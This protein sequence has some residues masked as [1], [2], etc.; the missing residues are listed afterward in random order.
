MDVA[1]SH[2]SQTQLIA[3]S[4]AVGG[5]DFAV[6]SLAMYR[7]STLMASVLFIIG[8]W[9]CGGAKPEVVAAD[10][11]CVDVVHARQAENR[12]DEAIAMSGRCVAETPADPGAHDARGEVLLAAGRFDEA[13]QAFAAA[14]A[15]QP[16][17][18]RAHGGLACVRFHR[19]DDAGGLEALRAGI[20]LTPER[21]PTYVRTRLFEDLATAELMAGRQAEAFEAIRMSVEAQGLSPATAEAATRVG[22]ARLLLQIDH[23]AEAVTE[24]RAAHVE[25]AEGFVATAV[26]ALEITARAAGGDGEGAALASVGFTKELGA[27]HP[28]TFE[29]ALAAALAL[30][31]F[32]TAR[33]VLARMAQVDPY[34]E[35]QGE[36]WLA[37]ALG[38]LGHAAEAR[39]VYERIKGRYL[40]SLQSVMV[41]RAAIAAEEKAGGDGVASGAR[42]GGGE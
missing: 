2:E 27:E 13:E 21:D 3:R 31:D 15:Q 5:G 38:K 7:S 25:G 9:G 32:E 6:E 17:F 39:E 12:L 33:E 42:R 11:T 20:A 35:E 26:R 10:A 1:V 23:V 22:R 28:R 37:R 34:A 14:L 30:G 41:R 36:L 24:L 29:P 4:I 18:A 16:D 40:R 8:F 19:G